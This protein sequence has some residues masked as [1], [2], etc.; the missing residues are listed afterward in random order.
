M[1]ENLSWLIVWARKLILFLKFQKKILTCNFEVQWIF[2]IDP[3]PIF[4][5]EFTVLLFF[6][7]SSWT[8]SSKSI[9]AIE[10]FHWPLYHIPKP[11]IMFLR[12]FF[13]KSPTCAGVETNGPFSIEI[14]N[15]VDFKCDKWTA[16]NSIATDRNGLGNSFY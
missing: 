16:W 15:L 2:L 13:L 1:V 14:G 10:K 6:S 8:S 11:H 4:I 5:K 3:S 7:W 12:V 9:W